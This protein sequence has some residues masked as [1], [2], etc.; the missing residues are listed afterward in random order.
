MDSFHSLARR[1]QDQRVEFLGRQTV[2]MPKASYVLKVPSLPTTTTPLVLRLK[3]TMAKWT[4]KDPTSDESYTAEM[5][6]LA[7]RI[8]CRKVEW[9]EAT[10]WELFA[11][12]YP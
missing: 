9:F 5:D 1:R 3:A 10:N 8:K 2:W 12:C 6:G 4:V 7:T 11:K